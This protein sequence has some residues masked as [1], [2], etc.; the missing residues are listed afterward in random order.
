MI[1]S[2][3]SHLHPDSGQNNFFKAIYNLLKEISIIQSLGGQSHKAI[4]RLGDNRTTA[5]VFVLPILISYFCVCQEDLQIKDQRRKECRK[6]H[7]VC[8]PNFLE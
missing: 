4:Y 2:V 3:P 5:Q 6:T 8:D 1:H 7:L